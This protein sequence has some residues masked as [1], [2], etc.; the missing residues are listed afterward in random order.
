VEKNKVYVGG[1]DNKLWK[2]DMA[3]AGYSSNAYLR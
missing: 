1:E 3:A 2:Y